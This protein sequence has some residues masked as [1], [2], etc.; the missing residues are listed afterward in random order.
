MGLRLASR[1]VAFWHVYTVSYCL[2]HIVAYF[3]REVWLGGVSV[4]L[5]YPKEEK[6]QLRVA[7]DLK[8]SLVVVAS[9]H[10]VPVSELVRKV[11]QEFVDG[12]PKA[13]LVK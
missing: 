4:K 2:R 6:L 13:G 9:Q 11:L 3:G 7:A 10:G 5:D 12:Q 1:F 8:A